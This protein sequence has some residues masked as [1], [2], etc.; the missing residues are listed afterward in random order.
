MRVI[1]Y[2]TLLL[3]PWFAAAQNDE[4]SIK[5]TINRL[6]DGMRQSD[7]KSVRGCFT[8]TAI[9]QTVSR[10]KDGEIMVRTDHVDSF[11]ASLAK[12]HDLYD[13]RIVFESIRI[14]GS[15]ASVWTPYRFFVGSRLNHCG[16]NSFQLVKT[17]DGWKIQYLIDT[18]RKEGCH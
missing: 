4:D 12:P 13:E 15:L 18:R 1:A 17:Q 5:E 8:Q 6:F 9:L 11:A 14:D 3:L 2:L 10:N 7:S 16:V